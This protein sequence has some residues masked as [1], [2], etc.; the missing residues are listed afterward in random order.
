MAET[1]NQDNYTFYTKLSR[2]PIGREV[3]KNMAE[4]NKSL[5]REAR[6]QE[7]AA[8]KVAQ[9]REMKARL[10][11]NVLFIRDSKKK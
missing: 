2:D 1:K 10:I 8:R 9:D 3:L 7:E 5:A 11:Y 6:A 4:F